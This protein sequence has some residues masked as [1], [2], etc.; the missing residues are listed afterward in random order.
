VSR[1]NSEP[2]PPT[3]EVKGPPIPSSTC[4]SYESTGLP[5]FYESR[6]GPKFTLIRF[7][8]VTEASDSGPIVGLSG[9]AASVT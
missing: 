3:M 6:S 5:P 2:S 7:S 4:N 1:L 8:L 9:T